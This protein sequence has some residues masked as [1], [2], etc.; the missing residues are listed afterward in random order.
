MRI[1]VMPY[2]YTIFLLLILFTSSLSAT[3]ANKF[4]AQVKQVELTRENDQYVLSADMAYS[5]NDTAKEALH[6]GVPLFWLVTIKVTAQ[7][8]L[9]WDK[10]V[11]KIKIRYRLQYH[12]LLNMYRVKNENTET[13]DNF[14]TLA[15]A[16]NAMSTLRNVAIMQT[17]VMQTTEN[18][19]LALKI[20]F[21]RNALPLPLQP[22]ALFNSQWYF[23]S[24][25]TFWAVK[26]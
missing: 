23:S 22:L 20:N 10:T 1:A 9:L 7:R 14:S 12:A 15:A 25:W 5:L 26:P 17:T 24:D 21:D 2:K 3:E 4:T 6:N 8:P 16:L 18:Y 19:T 13:V 11:A